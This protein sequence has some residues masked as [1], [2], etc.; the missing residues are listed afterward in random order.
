M[1]ASTHKKAVRL[2]TIAICLIAVS[3]GLSS[4][5]YSNYFKEVYD[6][7]SSQRGFIEIPRET[8]GVLCAFI[9]S[10]LAGFSD[11]TVSVISQ[12]LFVI[13]LIVMGCFSPSYG[14]MLAFLFINSLGSHLFMPL[15]DSIG[16]SLAK[17]GEVGQTIGNFKSKSNLFTMLTAC[18]VFIGFRSGIFSFKTGVIL[19]FVLAAIFGVAAIIIL[20]YLRK[21]IHKPKETKDKSPRF[22]V[23][24]Q[25]IP[26]YLVTIAYGCQKRIKLVFGPWLMVELLH[27]GADTL[28]L[29]SI[30]VAFADTFFSRIIGKMLDKRGLRFTLFFEGF[31]LAGISLILAFLAHGFEDALLPQTKIMYLIAC[32]F[33]IVAMMM[34]QV[35]MIHAYLVRSLA[36]EANEITKTLSVGLSVDHVMAV[37]ISSVM[38]VVWSVFGSEYVF[39]MAAFASVVQIGV[40]I[41][42]HRVQ[43]HL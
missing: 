2:F 8:P 28:A 39:I 14:I 34:D 17:E 24:K 1:D 12:I 5:N 11:V 6:V 43:Q 23:R 13:G 42:V 22:I 10:A 29:L 38:G 19:P 3:I 25:Y 20:I 33:Y 27:M 26:Y 21:Y 32:F 40:G 9:I 18:V 16:M 7:T 36:V 30:I 35:N 41:Y 31:Y 15:N 37:V 4:A